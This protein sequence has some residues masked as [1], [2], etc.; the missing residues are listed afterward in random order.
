MKPRKATRREALTILGGA[1]V[2]ATFGCG[3]TSGTDTGTAPS[4]GSPT[5]GGPASASC[6]VSPTETL[7]PYP[8]LTDMVRSDIRQGSAGLPLTLAITVVNV[9]NACSPV[10]NAM[11]D[12][13]QCDS[14]G[15]YSQYS[16]PGFDGRN[17]TFLRGIQTTGADGRVTFLTVYPGWY[18]GRATH[19]HVEVSLGGRSIKVTQIAFPENVTAA[20]YGSGVYAAKGQSPTSNARDSVFADGVASEMATVSGDTASGYVGTFQVG[21]AL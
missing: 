7:G 17:E 4:G 12:L 18:A 14:Q 10:P 3:G 8:S 19:I 9:N 1:S 5:S 2:A 11:V 20:V 15:R 21:V 13:W 16:Q 6:V